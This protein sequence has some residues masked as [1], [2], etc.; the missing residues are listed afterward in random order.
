MVC[1]WSRA[2]WTSAI[3]AAGGAIAGA[4]YVLARRAIT[5]TWTILIYRVALGELVRLKVSEPYVVVA[6][7]IAGLAV[8]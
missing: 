5:D 7:A 6:A 1:V 8:T 4:G 2:C 3:A